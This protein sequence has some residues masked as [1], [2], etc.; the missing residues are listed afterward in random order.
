MTNKVS[1]VAALA[2]VVT[3]GIASSA[4]AVLLFDSSFDYG[5]SS[6]DLGTASGGQWGGSGTTQYDANTNLTWPGYKSAGGSGTMTTSNV[7][8]TV[9]HNPDISKV[10]TVAGD[11]YISFLLKG[12]TDMWVRAF[13]MIFQA[14]GGGN[15]LKLL[16]N[17][18]NAGVDSGIPTGDAPHTTKLV[19]MKVTSD[20]GAGTDQMGLAV[21][22]DL[23]APNAMADL[24]MALNINT[25]NDRDWSV[26]DGSLYFQ[27]SRAPGGDQMWVDEVR[28]ATSLGEVI[29]E[30]ASMTLLAM[31]GLAMLRRRR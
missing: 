13:R 18:E 5:P 31:G 14:R 19:V 29:P 25:T 22:P 8:L 28:W 2:A 15:T 24:E 1:V 6:G 9:A 11:Y 23:L 12:R 10:D 7:P 21:N 17:D 27:F 16:N 30:P 3:L 20:G 4:S 26:G